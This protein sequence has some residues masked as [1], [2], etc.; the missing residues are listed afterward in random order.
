[1]QEITLKNGNS[2]EMEKITF[3]DRERI[4]TSLMNQYESAVKKLAY[5]YMK[6]SEMAKDI[7]QEVFFTCFKQIHTIRGDSIKAW[8]FR[9]TINKCLDVLRKNTYKQSLTSYSLFENLPSME[10][11]PECIVVI[12]FTTKKL[13]NSINE[14][15]V[16]YREV[17]K[18]FYLEELC[19]KEISSKLGLN[20]DTVK[21]RLYRGRMLLKDK[22]NAI[23]SSPNA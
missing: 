18:L 7:S 2:I 11:T 14:L 23:L 16:I 20:S 4:T 15:P 8:I 19:I 17:L 22:L 12:K 9:I 13:L 21:T 6:D 1:M 3:E 10:R 5:S